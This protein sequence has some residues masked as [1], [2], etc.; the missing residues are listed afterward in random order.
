MLF[1]LRLCVIQLDKISGLDLCL[2]NPLAL[3][4]S[5]DLQG[6]QLVQIKV[7]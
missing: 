7:V 5:E 6:E 1:N 3:E 4:N 2:R